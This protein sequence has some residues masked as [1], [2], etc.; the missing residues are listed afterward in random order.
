MTSSQF[1]GILD[2][3]T[4]F[5]SDNLRHLFRRVNTT[6]IFNNFKELAVRFLR[7][8]TSQCAFL[9]IVIVQYCVFIGPPA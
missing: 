9:V 3:F 1:K 6:V 8:D 7:F 4:D 2:R 5:T